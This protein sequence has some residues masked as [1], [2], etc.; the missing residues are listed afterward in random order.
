MRFALALEY[1]GAGFCGFQSQPSHCSVQD[2]LE[3]AL[4]AVASVPVNVTAAGRTDAGVHATSQ[5]VHFDNDAERSTTA[6]VRGVNTHLPQDAAVL[7]ARPVAPDFHARFSATARHYTYLLLDRAERPGLAARRVGWYHR[8]LDV[9]AMAEGAALITGSR[10]FSSFRAAECQAKTPVRTLSRLDVMRDGPYVRFEFTA[11]AF[12]HHM[13]RNI[14]GAL[15]YVGVHK[16]QPAWLVE[17]VDARD[18]T[19][20]PPTFAPDGLYFGGADYDTRFDLPS[21]R[22]AVA[23]PAA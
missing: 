4:G 13:V 21:T 10:D 9:E 8:A 3:R 22:R 15:V 18:R 14:V 11:N 6:W 5:V 7:W 1:N 20:A 16:V 12:L 17:L 23:L 2:A 19:L